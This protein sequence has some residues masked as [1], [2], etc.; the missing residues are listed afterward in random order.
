MGKLYKKEEESLLN[1]KKKREEVK[2]KNKLEKSKGNKNYNGINQYNNYMGLYVNQIQSNIN[3]PQG[4]I[5]GY[6]LGMN[7]PY[8]FPIQMMRYNSYFPQYQLEQPKTL[9]ENINMIY[10]RGIVN[11]II[12]AFYIKECLDKLKNNEKRKVPVSVLEEEKC[13]NKKDN[14]KKDDNKNEIKDLEKGKND[15]G[16][17]TNNKNEQDNSNEQKNELK[18]P[19]FLDN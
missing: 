16:I 5:D 7:Q 13:I 6:Y 9:E 15:E 10:Q 4:Y 1:K 17:N 11:N 19:E 3:H 18:K 2:Q 14:N 8:Q 12:G